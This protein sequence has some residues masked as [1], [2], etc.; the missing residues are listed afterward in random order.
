MVVYTLCWASNSYWSYPLIDLIWMPLSLFHW[1]ETIKINY[2]W[3]SC[4]QPSGDSTSEVLVAPKP[5]KSDAEESKL[6][7]QDKP[8]KLKSDQEKVKS[9]DD[10]SS[11][12]EPEKESK[13]L[14]PWSQAIA[15]FGMPKIPNKKSKVSLSCLMYIHVLFVAFLSSCIAVK[16]NHLVLSTAHK[17]KV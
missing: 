8:G 1:K 15:T 11:S 9:S 5:A 4:L 17:V 10:K 3:D 13:F 2:W 12:S 6:D 7:T 16:P 14:D